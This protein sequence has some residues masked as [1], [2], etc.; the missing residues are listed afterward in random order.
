MK[1]HNSEK[2]EHRPHAVLFDMDN[3]LYPYDLAHTAGWQAVQDKMCGMFSITAKDFDKMS[4]A[5]RTE[6][7]SRLDGTASS[8]SRLLY[9]HLMLEVMGLGSRVL[10]ALDLEQTYWRTFLRKAVLFDGVKELINIIRFFDI[11]A[12]VVTNLAAHTQF[13]KL[14]YWELDSCF[15][16]VV[17]SEEAGFDKP[18]QAIF[19]LALD[20][21]QPAGDIVWMIGDDLEKDI[22]GAREGIG[23]VTLQK[24][25]QG[26]STGRGHMTPD[27]TFSSFHEVHKFI[28]QLAST[29]MEDIA[30]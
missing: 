14:V 5:A 4:Q 24:T 15:D 29:G 25:H 30:Q 9:F 26:V 1:I 12:A 22:R 20:K 6:V 23:A 13:K 18:H 21:I 7:K 11:P 10:L 27:A 2:F 19:T 28:R 17:T 16:Y 3:T 8:H